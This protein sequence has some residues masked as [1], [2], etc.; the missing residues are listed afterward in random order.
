[1]ALTS[2]TLQD[3]L[4]PSAY[5]DVV[6]IAESK[7]MDLNAETI[8]SLM[9]TRPYWRKDGAA[10]PQPQP[11]GFSAPAPTPA[12][13]PQPQANPMEGAVGGLPAD[14]ATLPEQEEPAP[15]P[16]PMAPAAQKEKSV[17]TRLGSQPHAAG[18]GSG[19]SPEEL[20]KSLAGVGR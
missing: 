8:R 19:M 3:G 16:A 7:G 9:E 6:A 13:A 5:D 11:Q 17:L 14:L 18:N 12:P 10:A 2:A 20:A 4:D 1:M 15:A